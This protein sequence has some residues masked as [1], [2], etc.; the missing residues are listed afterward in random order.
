M[1]SGLSVCAYVSI[2]LKT[3]ELLEIKTSFCEHRYTIK[4]SWP[5]LIEKVLASRSNQEKM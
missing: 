1:L 2:G 3:S 4:I 5:S